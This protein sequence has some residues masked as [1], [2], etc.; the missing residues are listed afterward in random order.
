MLTS[1]EVGTRPDVKLWSIKKERMGIS[2]GAE[3]ARGSET[4]QAQSERK[5]LQEDMIASTGRPR[6]DFSVSKTL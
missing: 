6:C 2:V 4:I 1:S 5:F 3:E